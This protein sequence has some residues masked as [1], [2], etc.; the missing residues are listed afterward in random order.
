[1]YVLVTQTVARRRRPRGVDPKRTDREVP[2]QKLPEY[3]E[4]DEVGAIMRAADDPHA[5]LLMLE[6]WRAGLR[7]SEA[8]AVEV[9]D[10]SLESHKPTLKV[11]SGKGRRARVVPV[12][13]ELPAAFR[14]AP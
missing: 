5:R 12:H 1:M 7:V 13:P 11:R 6:Q 3:L 9:S 8:L 14:M 4:A 10:L 2:T